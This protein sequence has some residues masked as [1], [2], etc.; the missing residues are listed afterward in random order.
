MTWFGVA[1]R[2]YNKLH[3]WCNKRIAI[4]PV[5]VNFF[6]SRVRALGEPRLFVA[7]GGE[8]SHAAS[9]ISAGSL[10]LAGIHLEEIFGV[11]LQVLQMDAV[12][13]RFCL[14][15]VRVSGFG[16]LAQLIGVRSIMDDAA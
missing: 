10:P 6:G 11:G 5:R 15:I 16:G 1:G 13:L 4:K 2:N 9:S 3:L 14:L 7:F 8:L 12:I